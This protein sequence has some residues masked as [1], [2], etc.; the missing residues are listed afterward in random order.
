MPELRKK[1]GGEKTPKRQKP[2]KQFVY[3][4]KEQLILQR[5]AKRVEEDLAVKDKS[6]EWLAFQVGVARSTVR[7]LIQAKSNPRLLTLNAI[8]EGLGYE[9]VV[10]LLLRTKK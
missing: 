2:Q 3:T 1:Q 10:E 6:V 9:D 4:S 5:L 8:A 7:E